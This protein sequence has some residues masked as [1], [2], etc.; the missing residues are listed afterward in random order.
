MKTSLIS[1]DSMI[2]IIIEAWLAYILI[3]IFLRV[4]LVERNTSKED[5]K[6]Y[7]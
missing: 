7:W 3:I 2:M 5:D 4:N 1:I 6:P